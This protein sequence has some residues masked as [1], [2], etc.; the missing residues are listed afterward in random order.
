MITIN[1]LPEE[2]RRHIR[3]SIK[4]LAVGYSALAVAAS[5]L[6]W[7][8]W[9]VFGVSPTLETQRASL[10]TEMAGLAPRVTYHQVL[11]K[12]AAFHAS[13]EDTLRTITSSRVLWTQVLD[14]L[15]DVVNRGHE[16]ERHTIWFDDITGSLSDGVGPSKEGVGQLEAQGHSGSGEIDQISH[17]LADLTDREISGLP[18]VFGSPSAPEGRRNASDPT[19][20]P[21]VDFSFPLHLELLP[22]DQRHQGTPVAFPSQSPAPEAQQPGGAR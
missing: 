19:V 8:G 4:L 16:G 11:S 6:A 3:P 15:T 20:V 14:D 2:Y 18:G 13:R 21:S 7:W 12:E 9:L 22:S 1:L 17:F 5:L 10:E